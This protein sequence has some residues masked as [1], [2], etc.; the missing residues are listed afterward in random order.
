MLC[1]WLPSFRPLGAYIFSF[2]NSLSLYFLFLYLPRTCQGGVSC[3][4]RSSARW[5]CSFS[6]PRGPSPSP[7]PSDPLPGAWAGLQMQFG[8]FRSWRFKMG[9]VSLQQVLNAKGGRLSVCKERSQQ[10]IL[11]I[12]WA[13]VQQRPFPEEMGL[14]CPS[15]SFQKTSKRLSQSSKGL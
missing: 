1:V 7:E 3:H 13:K 12:R 6:Q 14:L 15:G 9:S 11:E 2:L 8:A 4:S 10:G 5:G